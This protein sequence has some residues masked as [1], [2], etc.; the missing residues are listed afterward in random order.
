M[1]SSNLITRSSASGAEYRSFLFITLWFVSN[2]CRVIV[3]YML[4]TSNVRIICRIF[5]LFLEEKRKGLSKG[6]LYRSRRGTG[7]GEKWGFL[8]AW[9]QRM[10]RYEQWEGSGRGS[11][12]LNGRRGK[13]PGPLAQ[14][15]GQEPLPAQMIQ[16]SYSRSTSAQP[17]LAG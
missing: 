17:N 6:C 12:R 10:D 3:V 15:N 5:I 4:R 9:V 16:D 11:G 2:Y 1:F 13:H 14:K 7:T 8:L